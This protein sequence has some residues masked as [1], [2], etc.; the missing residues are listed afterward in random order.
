MEGGSVIKPLEVMD[1]RAA[2]RAVS[3]E[4]DFEW[5]FVHTCSHRWIK[6]GSW[7]S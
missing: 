5:A 7:K 4:V 3:I 6:R 2:E 1:K